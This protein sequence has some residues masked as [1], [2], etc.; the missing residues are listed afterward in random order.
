MTIER[1]EVMI[2]PA[3]TVSREA[4]NVAMFTIKHV[5]FYTRPL[6]LIYTFT[7]AYRFLRSLLNYL[8]SQTYNCIDDFY[9]FNDAKLR[10]ESFSSKKRIFIS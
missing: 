8:R 6:S 5:L 3:D 9:K 4:L 1:F 7:N 2:Y 10:S